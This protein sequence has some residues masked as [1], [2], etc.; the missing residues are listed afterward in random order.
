MTIDQTF[1]AISARL[2][3]DPHAVAIPII[4]QLQ[5][6]YGERYEAALRGKGIVFVIWAGAGLPASGNDDDAVILNNE[7]TIFVCENRRANATGV[8]AIEWVQ[9]LLRI[10]HFSG[11]PQT[12]G[13]PQIR[14][15]ANGPAYEL[16]DLSAGLV[17]YA[18][19]L[20]VTTT[21]D[22]GSPAPAL[23][24]APQPASVSEN[25]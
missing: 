25:P 3:A 14:H 9:H 4:S 5:R 7:M 18:V 11:N 1:S 16:G 20:V 8:S 22:I 19:N 21:D 24:N 6:D 12:P 2:A 10:L 23:I 13:R 15:S 17:T